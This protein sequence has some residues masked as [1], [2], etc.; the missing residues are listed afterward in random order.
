MISGKNIISNDVY[1]TSHAKLVW[2]VFNAHFLV[3]HPR[4]IGHVLSVAESIRS[5]P[6]SAGHSVLVYPTPIDKWYA[7][8]LPRKHRSS[9]MIGNS[10]KQEIFAGS[11][12][13]LNE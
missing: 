9:K 8:V 5:C 7:S 1:R 4:C 12:T 2:E 10:R 13:N 6:I 3:N 11:L